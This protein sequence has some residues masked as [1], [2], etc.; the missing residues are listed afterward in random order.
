MELKIE[1]ALVI[2]EGKH[3]GKI[4]DIQYREKPYAYTDLVIELANGLKLK[5]GYATKVTPVSKLGRLML[6]F[7][8]S[9]EVGKSIDV[10][11][12]FVG[13]GCTFLVEKDGNFNNIIPKSLKPVEE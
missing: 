9:L 4:I 13:K 5:A 11:D 12:V 10:E 3:I 1:E 8:A 7:G 2:E 6:D